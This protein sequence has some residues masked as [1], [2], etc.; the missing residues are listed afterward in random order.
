ME[1]ESEAIVV[2]RQDLG[3]TDRVVRLIC[4]AHGRVDVVARGARA[5]RKRFAGALDPGT[6]VRATWR[7][8]RGELATLV[9]A[10]V[11]GAPRRARQD[12]GRVVLLAYGCDVVLLLSTHGLAG[13]RGFG[14]LEAW[15]A[16]LEADPGPGAASRVAFEAKAL[17]FAGLR[18]QL[19]QCAVCGLPLAGTVRFDP[20]AGGG[21]H[22]H[23]G[24]GT[25][26]DAAA[27]AEV[28]ALLHTPLAQTP[29]VP[30]PTG[31]GWL[32]TDFIEYQC[33]AG[34][35]ARALLDVEGA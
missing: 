22:G 34:L 4:A 14:L 26:V 18:P 10:D 13:D 30:V 35:R 31:C 9:T 16:L 29:E 15:L 6:R 32:L 2:G 3:D 11:V 24:H 25:A 21:V 7:S 1:H 23:C 12:Y 33:H 20:E 28:D 5:S 8:G 27:L 17:A 19:R